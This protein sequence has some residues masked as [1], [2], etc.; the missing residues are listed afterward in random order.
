MSARTRYLLSMTCLALF[1]AITTAFVQHK[2]IERL[3]A[4]QIEEELGFTAADVK[5]P[6]QM[7]QVVTIQQQLD[8]GESINPKQ[9]DQLIAIVNGP[10]DVILQ[11][12]ALA[13]LMDL[14]RPNILSSQQKKEVASATLISLKSPE[15]VVR[16]TSVMLLGRLGDQSAVPV[17]LPLLND[18][19]EGVRKSTKKALERL[20]KSAPAPGR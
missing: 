12:N 20:Q 4:Q 18:P 10:Q 14:A 19:E 5:N 7:R 15:L 8:R 9:V 2:R 16:R 17:L 6:F 11:T 3:H 13:T 1:V